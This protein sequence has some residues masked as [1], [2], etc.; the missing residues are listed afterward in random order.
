M[1]KVNR[2]DRNK[3]NRTTATQG[4]CWA[5]WESPIALC[6]LRH[7]RGAYT[8]EKQVP[9]SF[10]AS[11]TSGLPCDAQ[12]DLCQPQLSSSPREGCWY[13]VLGKKGNKMG[14]GRGV[15]A[16]KQACA[17]QGVSQGCG[18]EKRDKWK[19]F[20][21]PKMWTSTRKYLLNRTGV[22]PHKRW[23]STKAKHS[24]G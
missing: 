16:R 2:I 13:Q 10:S 1:S 3:V 12:E 20:L 14:L 23:K 24:K 11:C 5:S 22:E 6:Y 21:I 17:F 15:T 9:K 19:E 4:L 18:K 8:S 7:P